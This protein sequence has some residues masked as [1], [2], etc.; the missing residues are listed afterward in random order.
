MKTKIVIFVSGGVVN[1]VFSN[2]PDVMVEL[3]DYDNRE[4]MTEKEAEADEE[5][6]EKLEVE[7]PHNVF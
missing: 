3:I 4:E 5:R 6:E 7:C 1:D 2:N